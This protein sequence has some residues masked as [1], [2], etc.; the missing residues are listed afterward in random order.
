MKKRKKKNISLV[1]V[2]VGVGK[3]KSFWKLVKR[4][5]S[6]TLLWRPKHQ[7]SI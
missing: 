4:E 6:W 5:E 2:G 3:K 7:N 1:G